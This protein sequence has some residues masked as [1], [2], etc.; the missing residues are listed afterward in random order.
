M[1]KLIWLFAFIV[2]AFTLQARSDSYKSGS[3]L[4]KI[5]GKD[6][7]NPSYLLGTFHLKPGEYIDSIPGARASLEASEQVIGEIDTKDMMSE[8]MVMQQ[9]MMMPADTT[10]H[11]LYND[12]DYQTVDEGLKAIFG[13]GLEQLGK[14]KPSGIQMIYL[15]ILITRYYPGLNPMNM[16]DAYIQ[17]EAAENQKPVHGLESLEGQCFVLFE[18][19]SLERQAELL[20]CNIRSSEGK[21]ALDEMKILLDRM[22][23]DY[24]RGALNELYKIYASDPSN[25]CPNTPEEL[26]I[27]NK[28]RNDAWM[29]KLPELMRDKSSFIAVGA[30]HLAGEEGLLNQ[31]EKAGYQVEAV[32]N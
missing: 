16:L 14:L 20:L 25:P 22:E 4:W 13:T 19:S 6:L 2:I 3:L 1:K 5:S 28:S 7:S 31:L 32:K 12:S 18:S 17:K 15:Q 8:M 27:I 11:M 23:T 29:K 24:N 21:D 9:K 30:L 10:Y 26:D